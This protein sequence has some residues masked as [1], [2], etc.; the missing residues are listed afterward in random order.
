LRQQLDELIVRDITPIDPDF[1]LTQ[2]VKGI[3]Y[4]D[5]QALTAENTAILEWYILGDKFLLSSSPPNHQ[6]L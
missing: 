2:E 3:L 1:L 4:S 6:H 5:I